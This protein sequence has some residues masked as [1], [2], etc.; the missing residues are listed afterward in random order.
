ML[1]ERF[2]KTSF[3]ALGVIGLVSCSTEKEVPKPEALK[4]PELVAK[5]SALVNGLGACGFCHGLNPDP[6]SPLAGGRAW[7]DRYGRVTA[8]NITPSKSGLGL[9]TTDQIISAIRGGISKDGEPL[10]VEVHRGAEWISDAD[11]LAIS[12]YLKSLPPIDNQVSRRTI[13]FIDRNTTGFFESR[14]DVEGYVPEIDRRHE[15][16][17][18]E[19]LVSHVARCTQCHNSEKTVFSGEEALAGGKDIKTDD[20]LKVAPGIANST[21]YGVGSWSEA[22]IVSF[23]RSGVTPEKREIDSRFCPVRFYARAEPSDLTA[24]A[25]YLKSG[26]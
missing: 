26:S 14:R 23:L 24:I 5:G 12:A 3:L 6:D 20:G 9:W 10:S 8:P 16:E 2:F 11:A 17:Y 18:G 4:S 19:Y 21:L 22:D 7:E 15:V 1:I 13:S 25:K